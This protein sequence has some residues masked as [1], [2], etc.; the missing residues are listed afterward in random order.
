MLRSQ[1][2]QNFGQ[3]IE[4]LRNHARVPDAAIR[5]EEATIVYLL[6]P[7]SFL[8]DAF[9][10]P[11][12]QRLLAAGKRVALV[13][14][15]MHMAPAQIGSCEVLG[16][17]AFARVPP[18]AALAINMANTPFVHGLFTAIAWRANV[19]VL[20]IIPVLD[21]FGLSVIYQS[22]ETMRLATLARLVDYAALA[23]KLDDPLSIQTLGACLEMR[24]TLNRNAVLPILCSLEDEYFSPYPAGKDVTFALGSQEILCDVGAH[25]GTTIRKFLTATR[26]RYDA[27][28]AF[29]PDVGS[30]AALQRGCFEHLANF[31]P[32]NI[33]LSNARSKLGFSE[34]GTMGSRLDDNGNVQVQASTLDDE[35]EHATFIKMDVEGHEAKI[36]QGAR[37]L[38]AKS[39]PRLAITGYHFADDLL[40]IVQ[41]VREIEPAYRLRLRHHS[42]YYYDTILYAD[43]P[44]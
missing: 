30:F 24:V 41:L 34:T 17:E 3:L 29:E 38:I 36:L 22:A 37:R 39:K 10:I 33:A 21:A 25:V 19:P 23:E 14:D 7:S 40:D 4:V 27:I 18:S 1:S 35:I 6:A 9:T 32:R 2:L 28:H 5:L 20:D 15:T 16:T 11:I 12:A 42:F 44:S 26:W 43:I 31:H 8:G 13:D